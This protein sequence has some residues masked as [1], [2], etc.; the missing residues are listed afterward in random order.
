MT[1]QVEALPKAVQR[2]TACWPVGAGQATPHAP[3]WAVVDR[4][5]SQ[6]FAVLPSQSAN[7]L[8]HTYRQVPISQVVTVFGREAQAVAQPPQCARSVA[9]FASHPVPAMPSQSA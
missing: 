6:P 4:F 7:P 1:P 5:A 3:Q 9:V 8:V 2:A